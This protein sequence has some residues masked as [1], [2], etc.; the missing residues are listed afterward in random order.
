MRCIGKTHPML[1]LFTYPSSL[2]KATVSLFLVL[3]TCSLSITNYD[4][5]D[6]AS[7]Q[8]IKGELWGI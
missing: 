4:I 8:P 3:L 2:R 5:C 1:A 7:S 6:K